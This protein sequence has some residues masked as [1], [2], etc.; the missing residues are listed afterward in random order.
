MEGQVNYLPDG[1]F[2]P[3][4]GNRPAPTLYSF[5]L[6]GIDGFFKM[7][8]VKP[9]FA[10]G[11]HITFEVDDNNNVNPETVKVN[12]PTNGSASVGTASQGTGPVTS[13]YAQ[14][15]GPDERQK[16]ICYQSARKDALEFCKLLHATGELPLPKT[17]GK[18]QEALAALVDSYTIQFYQ[19]TLNVANVPTTASTVE[20]TTT[21]ESTFTE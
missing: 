14:A 21:S 13:G 17:K 6:K 12:G 15:V 7:V 16:S 3:K 19:A 8:K 2:F 11:D 20:G 9:T 4:N 10:K 18:A 1:K 5:G